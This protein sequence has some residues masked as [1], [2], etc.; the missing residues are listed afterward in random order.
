MTKRYD[1]RKYVPMEGSA[2]WKVVQHFVAHPGVEIS[3]TELAAIA[4]ITPANVY[5]A[6][7]K[8]V[9]AGLLVIRR[10]R[11]INYYR[12]GPYLERIA[13]A[14][15]VAHSVSLDLIARLAV[16]KLK[17]QMLSAEA[18][19]ESC[20]TTRETI[21][22]ALATLVDER[23]LIRIDV[24]RN[25]E[26][27]FDYRYSSTYVPAPEDWLNISG[28]S[29]P[30]PHIS[31]VAPPKM[32]KAPPA[33]KP[34]PAPAPKP[35]APAA[36]KPAPAPQ[37]VF[38]KSASG[39]SGAKTTDVATPAGTANP[40]ILGFAIDN[41]PGSPLLRE[42][43]HTQVVPSVT[44]ASD[45]VCAMNSRGELAIDLDGT[46]DVITFPPAQALALKQFLDNTSILEE[47]SGRGLL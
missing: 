25:G 31:P 16:L 41:Q 42:L 30:Q 27:S 2:A 36:D 5:G 24:L 45:M 19:A 47:L 9:E 38:P 8:S 12:A 40:G 46:G 29:A 21:N 15:D 33:P 22:E 4:G 32:V 35:K 26:P 14:G 39:T 3:S 11:Q 34:A 7:N 20:N 44:E 10:D 13:P 18:L 37:P 6:I 23:K 1:P 17:G 43:L 28:R